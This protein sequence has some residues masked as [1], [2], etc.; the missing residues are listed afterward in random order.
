[1][2]NHSTRPK[3]LL[4]LKIHSFYIHI[5]SSL[6]KGGDPNKWYNPFVLNIAPKGWVLGTSARG[7]QSLE[8]QPSNNRLREGTSLTSILNESLS[9]LG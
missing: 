9:T 1:M 6:Y 7:G 3:T 2:D 8:K 4:S 5:L